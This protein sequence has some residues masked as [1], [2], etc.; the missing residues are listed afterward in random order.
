MRPRHLLA[1]A[2]AATLAVTACAEP[3]AGQHYR[4]LEQPVPTTAKPGQV[5]VIE[6]F[7]LGCPHCGEFEPGLQGWLKRKPATVAFVRVPATFNPF[8]KLMAK[9]Y[10]GLED[11]GAAERLVPLMFIAIHESRDPELLRPLGEWQNQLQR[12]DPATQAAAEAQVLAAMSGWVAARGGDRKKF[13]AALR[14]P[15]MA[16]RLGRADLLYRQYEVLGVPAMAVAGK[17]FTSAGR[18]FANRTYGEILDTIEH[19][20]ALESKPKR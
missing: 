13:D 8:F 11:I 17:Y 6:F 1:I 15:S 5:E 10:Y 19:L 20:V 14:S 4:V 7:S 12:G 9:V 16:L 18:P 2:A 3:V